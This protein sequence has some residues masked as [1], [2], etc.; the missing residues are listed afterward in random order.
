MG[1][2]PEN[3]IAQHNVT[4]YHVLTSI[5]YWLLKGKI[6][7]IPN[8]LILS[9]V[10]FKLSLKNSAV[11]IA[12]AFSKSFD[13]ALSIMGPLS[14]GLHVIVAGGISPWLVQGEIRCP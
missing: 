6:L 5:F 11:G 14:H 1:C 10:I 8:I 12:T 9:H 2:F 4:L 3:N 13:A 7:I